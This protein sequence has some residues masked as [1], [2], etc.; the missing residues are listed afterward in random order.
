MGK[1]RRQ[2]VV[3]RGYQ[4]NFADGERISIV[5]KKTL[6]VR[7]VGTRDNF[8][9]AHLLRVIVA[10]ESDDSV[11]DEFARV[12]NFALPRIR[13]LRPFEDI[14]PDTEVALKATMAMLWARSF[15]RELVAER[16][17]RAVVDEHVKGSDHRLTDAFRS[18]YGR[19]PDEGEIG[20]L[21]VERADEIRRSR[22]TDVEQ[23]SPTTTRPLTSS[24]PS[25]SPSTEQRPG[26]SSLPATIR[27]FSPEIPRC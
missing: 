23:S 19:D 12:E 9:L 15:A 8:V 2:H 4:R 22:V 13:R 16:V 3:P 11:E 20:R 7:T 24:S 14:A 21:Y 18:E 6:E 17:F 27:S 26:T 5:D 25:A 10:G 1:L